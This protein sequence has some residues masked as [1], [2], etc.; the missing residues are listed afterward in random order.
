MHVMSNA[1]KKPMRIKDPAEINVFYN[2]HAISLFVNE[3][4]ETETMTLRSLANR[5]PGC[6][7][8]SVLHWDL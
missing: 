4:I 3:A 5:L 1:Y 7:T 6:N 2:P 8:C